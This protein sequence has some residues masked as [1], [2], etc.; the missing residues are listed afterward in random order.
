MR[1]FV[2][3]HARVA[4]GGTTDCRLRLALVAFAV[5]C[6][7]LAGAASRAAASAFQLTDLG[8]LDSQA[9]AINDSGQ[10]AGAAS[11]KDS[12][13]ALRQ[14]AFFWTRSGGMVDLGADPGNDSRATALNN[15]GVVVGSGRYQGFDRG[16]AW[17]RA[18]G[19]VFLGTLPGVTDVAIPTA[20]NDSGQVVGYEGDH[21]FSWTPYGGMVDIGSLGY[22]GSTRPRAVNSSGQVV[23]GSG[24]HPFSWTKTG[25]MVDLGALPGRSGGEAF[26]V[27]SNGEVVGYSGTGGDAHAFAW[28]AAGGMVDLGALPSDGGESGASAVNDTGQVVGYSDF[29]GDLYPDLPGVMSAT[30]AFSWT[31]AGGMVDLGGDQNSAATAVNN[32]GQVVGYFATN[33]NFFSDAF[34]WTAADG[35]TRLKK[36]PGGEQGYA[37]DV[38]SV[39]QVAG[40]S[41]ADDGHVYAVVWSPR[42]TSSNYIRITGSSG[43]DTI[44]GFA[45]NDAIDGLGGND[46]LFGDGCGANAAA[47]RT[48]GNDTLNG[49]KGNDTL[50]GGPGNDKLNGGPGLNRYYGGPGNDT[51][52]ARNRRNEI[53]DCGPG[54]DH[55]TVDK[56]D[57]TR[58][59]EKVSRAKK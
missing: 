51:I 45:G 40:S 19:I 22:G 10:V 33:H 4:D 58:R 28:T 53:V 39:G 8:G 27:N 16:F 54:K 47:T 24:R 32:G 49:G 56:H 41:D 30:H 52:N 57:K 35:L 2:A 15:R 48:G 23:G 12:S 26:A 18:T 46:A 36:L 55:A 38:N 17:T 43:A 13:G 44:C 5:A 7:L 9:V 59:C 1:G 31:A 3:T 37:F 11:F 6:V 34:S 50:Y 42:A 25:G 29:G 21:G 14:H 20:V